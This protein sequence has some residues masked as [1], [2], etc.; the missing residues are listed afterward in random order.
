[1]GWGRKL[2]LLI[3]VVSVFTAPA[4]AQDACGDLYNITFTGNNPTNKTIFHTDNVLLSE[5]SYNSSAVITDIQ[6][7]LTYN[8]TFYTVTDTVT[9]LPNTT[10]TNSYYYNLPVD[11]ATYEVQLRLTNSSGGNCN[12]TY[13]VG[14]SRNDTQTTGKVIILLPLLFLGLAVLMLL[15]AMGVIRRD[16]VTS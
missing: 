15:I 6:I 10:G 16:K 9:D 2:L 5:Y 12:A 3:L 14:A 11:G 7:Q 8:D 1:M 13:N 4:L